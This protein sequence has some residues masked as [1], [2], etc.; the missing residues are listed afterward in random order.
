MFTLLNSKL[1][2]II[3]LKNVKSENEKDVLIS[4]TSIKNFVRIPE[5]NQSNIS[6]KTE[7]IS[8]AQQLLDCES[9]SLK[10]FVNFKNV[11]QQKFDKIELKDKKLYLSYKDNQT[12]CEIS[13]YEDLIKSIL[14]DELLKI[15]NEDGTYSLNDLKS[16]PMIDLI[17]QN[18]IKDYIDDLVFS[19]YF[20]IKS[21]NVG[22]EYKEEIKEKCKQHKFYKLINNQ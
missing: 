8:Q 18:I 12:I 16:I 21:E 4:I 20:K 7:L 15:I 6:I 3:L 19:L 5:I 1:N 17:K 22:F 10:D 11:L 2:T 13:E 9:F 14:K